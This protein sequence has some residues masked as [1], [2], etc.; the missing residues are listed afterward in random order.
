[1]KKTIV[2]VLALAAGASL[3]F[4]A[5]GKEAGSA[6]ASSSKY[7]GSYTFGGSTT[8]QPI[9]NVA[10]EQFTKANPGVKISYEGVGSGTGLKQLGEGTLSLAGSS[11]ELKQTELDAGLVPV[12]IAR[13]SI[14]PVVNKDCTVA[15]LTKDQLAGIYSGTITNWKAVGGKDEAIVV[16]NRDETSGTF[17]SFKELVLDPAKLAFTKNAIVAKENGEVAAKVASTPG[18]IGY[19]GLGYV[20]E[21]TKSGGKALSVNGVLAT[22]ETTLDKTYP[23]SRD[24]FMATKGAAKAGSVEKA[25]IDYVLSARGKIIVK[26]AGFVPLK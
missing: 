10:I 17:S 7:S 11:R 24:L 9:A 18:A 1:M 16:V 22:V 6:S 8:V 5:G 3:L 23:I 15:N 25:F 19:V 14:T 2:S 20:E 13:D 4:A 26:E 21:V 12:V